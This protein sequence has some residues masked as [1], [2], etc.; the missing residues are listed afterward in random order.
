[1]VHVP[2]K[3]KKFENEFYLHVHIFYFVLVML[4]YQKYCR[5]VGPA[6]EMAVRFS[7]QAHSL[8]PTVLKPTLSVISVIEMV[9]STLWEDIENTFLS[10]LSIVNHYVVQ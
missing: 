9:L 4:K 3:P 2:I 7:T 1:M 8:L 6:K 10:C 5:F